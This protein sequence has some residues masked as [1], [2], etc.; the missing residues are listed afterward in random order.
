MG[1][2]RQLARADAPCRRPSRSLLR[3][4][5]R[6]RR[7]PAYAA[8]V[9]PSRRG[10]RR[11]RPRGGPFTPSTH[12]VAYMLWSNPSRCR[13]WPRRLGGGSGKRGSWRAAPHQRHGAEAAELA[14][15]HPGGTWHASPSSN[16]TVPQKYGG[17]R[18]VPRHVRRMVRAEDPTTTVDIVGIPNGDALPVPASS[19]PC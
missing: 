9:D 16:R 12:A 3:H 5:L 11:Q 19:R 15:F 1:R 13:A 14:T 10:G 18:L 6:A 8:V 17:T 4:G 2:A 7:G